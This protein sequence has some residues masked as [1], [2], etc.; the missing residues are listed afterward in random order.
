MSETETSNFE[1]Q[2][3]GSIAAKMTAIQP[4]HCFTIG[5]NATKNWKHFSQRWKTYAIITGMN[6]LPRLK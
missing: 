4:P 5:T 1:Q 2:V 3:Q 6:N